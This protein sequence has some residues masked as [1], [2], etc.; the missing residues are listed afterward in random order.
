MKRAFPVILAA[1][2]AS[3]ATYAASPQVSPYAGL[4]NR[5][6]KAMAPE[7][8]ADLIAGRGA[9][10]ALAAELNGYPGPRHVL[11][12]ADRLQLSEGQRLRTGTLFTEMEATARDLGA[13]LV[14]L[15]GELETSFRSGEINKS[16]LVQL[17]A[18]IGDIEAELRA[19]HLG[20][21]LEMVELLSPQQRKE[22]DRLRGYTHNVR[23]GG[24]GGHGGHDRHA[25]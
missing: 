18:E 6:I 14:R 23:Q 2:V 10:Y 12:L 11:D 15:E 9:G 17:T 13:E 24:H 3:G 1:L 22:Y 7:R 8:M 5:E 21:H 4:E 16:H 19:T 25:N 20:Y